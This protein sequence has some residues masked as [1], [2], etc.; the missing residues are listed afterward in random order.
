ME[1]SPTQILKISMSVKGI[2]YII[3]YHSTFTWEFIVF[4]FVG[5]LKREFNQVFVN[6]LLS[7]GKRAHGLPVLHM[8][9]IGMIKNNSK[10]LLQNGQ[11]W[12]LAQAWDVQRRVG[13]KLNQTE[14]K[15]FI[16]R[17]ILEIVLFTDVIWICEMMSETFGWTFVEISLVKFSITRWYLGQFFFVPPSNDWVQQWS[18][19]KGSVQWWNIIEFNDGLYKIVFQLLR[20]LGTKIY[21]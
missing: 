15:L 21:I 6:R 2:L 1:C 17:T 5:C 8:W 14:L 7:D 9:S 11:K 16:Y 4:L 13:L 19:N 12:L 18:L 10:Y 3:P 20:C